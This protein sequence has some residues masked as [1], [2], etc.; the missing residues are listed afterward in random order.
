MCI[1]ARWNRIVCLWTIEYARC[2]VGDR[3]SKWDPGPTLHTIF[4]TP[5]RFTAPPPPFRRLRTSGEV[6]RR[7]ANRDRSKTQD[8]GGEQPPGRPNYCSKQAAAG[9]RIGDRPSRWGR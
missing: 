2:I 6:G 1:L 7:A 4:S 3:V 5:D 8:L 9:R